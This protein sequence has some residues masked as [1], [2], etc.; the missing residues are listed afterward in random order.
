MK[1]LAAI[2]VSSTILALCAT[3]QIQENEKEKQEN[4]AWTKAIQSASLE[5]LSQ[6]LE[7]F[8]KGIHASYIREHKAAIEADTPLRKQDET[9]F[10]SIIKEGNKPEFGLSSEQMGKE[11]RLWLQLASSRVGRVQFT[12]TE[13]GGH[14]KA[15]I[16]GSGMITIP[17]ELGRSAGNFGY[18]DAYGVMIMLGGKSVRTLNGQGIIFPITDLGFQDA[19]RGPMVPLGKGSVHV[20]RGRVE[21]FSMVFDGST[22]DPLRFA[23]SDG[24]EYVYLG[25]KGQVQSSNGKVVFSKK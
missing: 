21:L 11:Y 8:P 15:A 20:F 6:F 7:K 9:V 3:A 13:N 4:A 23:V 19:P 22:S 17:K 16:V 1:M 2:A 10:N 18:G 12:P 25:G 24:G 5:S 14:A